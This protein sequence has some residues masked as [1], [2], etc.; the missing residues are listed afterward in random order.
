MIRNC[1][2]KF[3]CEKKWSELLSIRGEPEVRYCTQCLQEVH[4][5]DNAQDLVL[6]MEKDWCVAI[7]RTLVIETKAVKSINETL[8]GSL[9]PAI[10]G[11]EN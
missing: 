3:E 1:Q 2:F 8:M 11:R 9:I 7:P 5:V 4:F 10:L 6:A